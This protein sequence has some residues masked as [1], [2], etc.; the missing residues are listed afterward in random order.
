[1]AKF[2]YDIAIIGGGIGGFASALTANALGKK[3]VVIEKG[4]LGGN[5]TWHTCIPS[6][7]LVKAGNICHQMRN[8]SSFGLK[9]LKKP[10]L[11]TDRVMDHV[12]SVVREVHEIDRPETF[13]KAGIDIIDGPAQFKDCNHVRIDGK[14]LS[15]KNF[16]IATGSRPFVPDIEGLDKIPYLTNE[17]VFDLDNLPK[18]IIILGGG[19]SGI[20]F[21]SAFVRLGV[22]VAI[23]E[24]S[25]RILNREDKELVDM[26]I[27]QL[28]SLGVKILTATKPLSFS[29]NGEGVKLAI[30]NSK[31]KKGELTAETVLV[32]T[33]RKLGLEALNL[34]KAGV[35]YT[36]RGILANKRLQ[37]SA[38]NIYACGDVV[39]PYQF[40][41]MAEYQGVMAARNICL[42][43][44]QNVNYNNV[45]WVI[46]SDPELG[47][48]GLT[49]EQA[50]KEYGNNI[51]VYRHNYNKVRRAVIDNAEE[52]MAKFI[53]DNKGKLIGAH[54]LGN[55]AEDLIHEA[56]LLI[57]LDKNLSKVHSVIHAYP[58]YSEAVIKRMA[59]LNYIESKQRNPLV[60]LALKLL[61]GFKDNLGSISD[62]L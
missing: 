35:K 22:G 60:R 32:T 2:D 52:G 56:Q 31:G 5:C 41:T 21:A 19:L 57:S 45:V 26:L 17:T 23:V 29:R 30:E 59:D 24:P 14:V 15:A 8:A 33:G 9:P 1:M 34:E 53:F 13:K 55:H 12:R 18:S 16:I 11:N 47:H 50:R 27:S 44:K 25:D 38:R 7:T 37:T 40:A 36:D 62:K 4:K 58:T 54:I 49:E 10:E 48:C 28:K 51:K 61:P 42:P 46:F 43:F 20:E 6:K 39:G 3:V